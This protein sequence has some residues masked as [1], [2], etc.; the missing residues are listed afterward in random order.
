MDELQK[1]LRR[2]EYERK[3]IQADIE[4]FINSLNSNRLRPDQE[5]QHKGWLRKYCEDYVD[6][7]NRI[8]ETEQQIN[9]LLP[10]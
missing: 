6:V 8:D 7:A 3:G 5:A 10:Q 1:Q 9:D 2:L 4:S